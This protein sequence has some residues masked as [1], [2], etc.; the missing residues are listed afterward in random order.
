MKL[1]M[2]VLITSWPA[3]GAQP[4]RNGAQQSRRMTAAAAGTGATGHGNRLNRAD[5][6]ASER[7]E[8]ELAFCA[9]VEHPGLNA[10]ATDRP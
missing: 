3:S 10:T 2:I 6:A 1:S 7:A 8:G 5:A 4:T 9:D